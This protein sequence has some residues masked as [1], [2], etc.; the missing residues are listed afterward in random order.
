MVTDYS[1]ELS[2]IIKEF[3]LET[4]YMPSSPEE[5]LIKN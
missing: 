1:L 2:R 3:S 4:L 5:I